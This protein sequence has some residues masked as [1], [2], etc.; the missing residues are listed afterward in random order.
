MRV[1]KLH[2]DRAITAVFAPELTNVLV[3]WQRCLSGF[4]IP[5]VISTGRPVSVPADDDRPTQT[6]GDPR[7]LIPGRPGSRNNHTRARG[8]GLPARVECNCLDRTMYHTIHHPLQACRRASPAAS[9]PPP[10]AIM[11]SSCSG[12]RKACRLTS[13]SSTSLSIIKMI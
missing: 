12:M 5:A 4:Q 11:I 8:P 13:E 7:P 3:H 9:P 1:E 6:D 10:P 2:L